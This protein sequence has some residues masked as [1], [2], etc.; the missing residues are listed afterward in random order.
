[1]TNQNVIWIFGDQHRRQLLSCM[2]DPNVRTPNIDNLA[3][4][5][6]NFTR[7][8]SNFPLCCP[9]R[10]TILSGRHAHDCIPGHNYRMPEGQKTLA[11]VLNEHGCHTAWFGKWHV[12]GPRVRHPDG[13]THSDKR[14]RHPSAPKDEPF[15][16]CF[17]VKP[18]EARGGFGTWIGYENNNSPHNIWVHG[19]DEDGEIDLHRLEGFETDALTDKL[20]AYLKRRA[21]EKTDSD[22]APFFAALSVQPPHD[23]YGAPEA[24]MKKYNPATM[25]MRGN[26]P[27]VSWVEERARR[28]YAG[29]CAMVENLDWNVGRIRQALR[30]TGLDT[31]TTLIF[32]SD[33]GDMHGSHGQFHK[34]SPW[35]ESAGIPFIIGGGLD[36]QGQPIRK[37]YDH[38]VSLVDLAPT[39]LGLFGIQA[40]DWMQGTDCSPFKTQSWDTPTPEHPNAV[41]LQNVIPTGHPDSND[42]AWRGIVTRDGWK[43]ICFED[44]DWLLFHLTEDPLEQVNLAHNTMFAGKRDELRNGLRHLLDQAGDRFQ[45]PGV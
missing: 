10:G 21:G 4:Y 24:F 23:P 12:D 1:M 42:R 11:H 13:S 31:R 36:V 19:H 2:G 33:H 37:R 7:A 30:E 25:H 43:Y 3:E 38:P 26:V 40:P 29:A 22:Q 17:E 35:E 45:V 18:M 15:R 39:T 9:A 34:T 28:E 8:Y 44:C 32:F 6:I 5:G 16:E 20:I 41:L 14:P 27:P